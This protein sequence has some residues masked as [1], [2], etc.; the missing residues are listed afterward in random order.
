MVADRFEG[1]FEGGPAELPF[2]V[3]LDLLRQ[4]LVVADKGDAIACSSHAVRPPVA[5]G[6]TCKGS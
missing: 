3:C 2:E 6:F 5:A 1:A 4:V